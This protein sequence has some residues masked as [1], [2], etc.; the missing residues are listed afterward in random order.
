VIP[1]RHCDPIISSNSYPSAEGRDILAKNERQVLGLQIKESNLFPDR[2]DETS[3]I[4]AQ[5]SSGCVELPTCTVCL[6]RLQSSVSGVEGGNDVPVSMRFRGNTGRC[7]ACRVYGAAIETG[8][9]GGRKEESQLQHCL[10]CG[11]WGNIWACLVC[12]HTGCGRYAMRHAEHHFTE[13]KHAF[14]LELATGRIWDYKRD[15]F[16]HV[17]G[18]WGRSRELE[19]ENS[20]RRENLDSRDRGA[21]SPC[22][23]SSASAVSKGYE[24]DTGKGNKGRDTQ[25]SGLLSKGGAGKTCS[26]SDSSRNSRGEEE[27][28]KGEYSSGY[29]FDYMSMTG[30]EDSGERSGA[31]DSVVVD[32]MGCLVE[33]YENLLESQLADQQIYFE[34]KLA[35]ETILL[36]EES[37]RRENRE[38]LRPSFQ[39]SSSGSGS[40]VIDSKKSSPCDLKKNN[41]S[42]SSSYE[43][44]LESIDAQL[45]GVG[46]I[47]IEISALEQQYCLALSALQE[48]EAQGR[49]IRKQND[50]LIREQKKQKDRVA[51]LGRCEEETKSRCEEEVGEL[52][53][54]I[55]DLS[56]YTKTKCQVASSHLKEELEVKHLIKINSII[57]YNEISLNQTIMNFH[58]QLV[59]FHPL[60]STHR[61]LYY[62]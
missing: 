34:K 17:E 62:I 38:N 24:G 33:R 19:E 13:T 56:F 35:R 26:V 7:A 44:D 14:S 1:I 30:G 8:T 4:S 11:L 2:H 27:G 61:S 52:E 28:E 16:V 48:M 60:L 40:S 37:M 12:G 3:L 57:I 49:A 46:E 5:I 58:C 54:Q 39:L 10:T 41:S 45:A 59:L 18:E 21:S 20:R 31:L 6:R 32:K 22:A 55:R 43:N 9:N 47:K 50:T 29:D 15:T 42:D 53:Q 25:F 36:L 23:S 51:E